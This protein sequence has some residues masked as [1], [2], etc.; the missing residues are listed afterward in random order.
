MEPP[1]TNHRLPQTAASRKLPPAID[2]DRLCAACAL[3]LALTAASSSFVAG[4]SIVGKPS[5]YT[6]NSKP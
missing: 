2:R 6:L 3:T 4:P 5:T 1:A